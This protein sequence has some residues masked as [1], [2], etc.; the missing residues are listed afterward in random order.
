M[1]A[2][3]NLSRRKTIIMIAHRLTTVQECDTIFFMEGG[4]LRASGSYGELIDSTAQFKK[5]AAV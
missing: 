1:D 3:R 2:M 5:M 4:A